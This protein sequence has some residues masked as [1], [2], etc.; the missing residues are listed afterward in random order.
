MGPYQGGQAERIRVPYADFNCLKVPGTPQDEL[1]DKFILL[2]DIFP[3]AYHATELAKVELGSTVAIYGAGPVGL[4]AAMSSRIKGASEVYVIDS[5]P[6]RLDKAQQIGAIPINFTGGQPG[7]ADPGPAQAQPRV[8]DSLR[9]GEEKM[10]GVMCGIDA[11]GYQAHDEGNPDIEKPTQ[12]LDDLIGL[13]NPTGAI[14]IIGV[15]MPQ[16]PGGVDPEAKHG[17]YRTAL[18]PVVGEGPSD[19]HRAGAGQ[20]LQRAAARPDPGRARRTRRS[21]SATTCPW[22]RPRT[23]TRSSTFA[24]TATPR[25][26]SS[27]SRGRKAFIGERS[28]IMAAKTTWQPHEEHGKLSTKDKD[29]LPESVF[30]FPKQR[31]EPL[32]DA[33]H[34]KNA[35]ARFD[36]VQDVSDEERDQAFAN[37][38]KAARHYGVDIEEK[39]WHDLGKTPHTH[40]KSH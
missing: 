16:D 34:V 13:V 9:P 18:G 19:R 28:K 1:E 30:A 11:V 26:S 10:K 33:S 25:S 40:N 23:P 39:S 7:R 12:I 29:E 21:S 3:T 37:I 6:A 22:R 20:A 27:R 36:Q 2:A 24:R 38:Q 5:V 32:T 15:F 35:L 31:K 4:L 14:G 8:Q 17:V